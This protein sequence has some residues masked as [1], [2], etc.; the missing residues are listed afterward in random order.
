VVALCENVGQPIWLAK[1]TP[2]GGYVSFGVKLLTADGRVLDDNRGRRQ[3]SRDVPAGSR[4]EVVTEVPVEGLK[5]GRYR[6]LFD[7]VNELVCWFQ[8][9]GS[10]VVERWVEIG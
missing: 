10:A 4:I 8:S 1:P 6:L 9:A 2:F 7:M 3:L 5:P